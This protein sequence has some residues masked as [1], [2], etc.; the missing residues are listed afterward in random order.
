M[1]RG[2]PRQTAPT[3]N[4]AASNIPAPARGRGNNKPQVPFPFKLVLNQWLLGL[5]GVDRLEQLAEHL[6][7]EGL[8]GL[9][10]N[11]VHRF[12]HALTAQPVQPDLSSDPFATGV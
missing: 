9:D 8:E 3:A 7:S 1:P 5:F 10:E 11:N 4:T 6:R 12:H 2:R